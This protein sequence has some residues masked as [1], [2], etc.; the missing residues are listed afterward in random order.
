MRRD[1]RVAE[2]SIPP[3]PNLRGPLTDPTAGAPEPAV[4]RRVQALVALRLLEVLRDMDLPGEI[5]EDEDPSQ[6]MPRRFG[7]SD[8][9]GRQI[10]TYRDDARRGARLTD[11]E[12][13]GLFR[14]V[15]RRPD[16]SQVFH[17]VGRLLAEE[18]RPAR[19]VRMLPRALQ[20]RKA[21]TRT[22]RSLKRL[23]GRQ[24]GGFVRAPFAI[25]GRSLL[26]I[27][28]DPGGDACHL[29]SGFCEEVL[30]Q[31]LGGSAKVTHTLCQGRGDD[32]CRWEGALVEMPATVV[33]R[34]RHA[35][36]EPPELDPDA[37]AAAA[38][39]NQPLTT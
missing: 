21:R 23:F 19:W 15:I 8:V 13:R 11:E 31:T 27:E 34:Q 1:Y 10:R 28:S 24:I 17:R 26:F 22:R 18:D 4:S 20:Y 16:G 38:G 32:Q 30:E 5:L 6:T 37:P 36:D 9:V 29:L 33:V 14:F 3:P 7:L 2:P 39:V 25:E 12:V 35:R